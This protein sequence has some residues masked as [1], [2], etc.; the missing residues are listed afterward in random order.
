MRVPRNVTAIKLDI[1]QFCLD[2]VGIFEP[3]PFADGANTVISLARGDFLGA[4]LSAAGMIPYLGDAAKLGKIPRYME[5]VEAAVQMAKR[6]AAYADELFPVIKRLES[7]LLRATEYLGDSLIRRVRVLIGQFYAAR[8]QAKLA[9]ISIRGLIKNRNMADVT[10]QQ[11]RNALAQTGIREAHNAHV[12]SRLIERGPTN[13]IFTLEDLVRRLRSAD[14]VS[15][16]ERNALRIDMGS[17]GSIIAN[18]ETLH[19]VTYLH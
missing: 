15:D 7:N 2:L 18:K 11:I 16:L 6:S 12:I 14:V 3:T 5:T 9:E 13:G 8:C 10:Q 19:W 1:V 4:G 17:Y